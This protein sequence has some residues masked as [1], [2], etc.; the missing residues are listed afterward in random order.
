MAISAIRKKSGIK[1]YPSSG[2][3]RFGII[4]FLLNNR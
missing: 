4:G 3:K 2:S 1:S